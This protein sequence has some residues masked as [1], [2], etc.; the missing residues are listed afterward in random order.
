MI[1][2]AAPVSARAFSVAMV[3]ATLWRPAIA[4]PRCSRRFYSASFLTGLAAVDVPAVAMPVDDELLVA[5]PTCKNHSFQFS[6]AER[7]LDIESGRLHHRPASLALVSPGAGSPQSSPPTLCFSPS[8]RPACA[9]AS[10]RLRPPRGL[11]AAAL[12]SLVRA[13]PYLLPGRDHR[14]A[15]SHDL[16]GDQDKKSQ[17]QTSDP[18]PGDFGGIGSQPGRW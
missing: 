13:D 2:H 18:D 8:S 5:Q 9:R 6:S 1:P 12:S 16:R 14:A 4:P 15:S 3:F 10:F 7:K 11:M 17:T